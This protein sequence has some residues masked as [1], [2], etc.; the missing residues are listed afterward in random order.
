MW[1]LVR[2]YNLVEP[3]LRRIS[4]LQAR[5]WPCGTARWTA[6]ETTSVRSV[7]SGA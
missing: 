2:R 3:M 7:S 1:S 5:T 6:R 4:L